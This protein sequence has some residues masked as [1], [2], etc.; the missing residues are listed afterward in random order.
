MS[1]DVPR[2]EKHLVDTNGSGFRDSTRVGEHHGA[3]W[4][5]TSALQSSYVSISLTSRIYILIIYSTSP[6]NLQGNF[7]SLG[8]K[9]AATGTRCGGLPLPFSPVQE[10]AESTIPRKSMYSRKRRPWCF[11]RRPDR[12]EVEWTTRNAQEALPRRIVEI[13]PVPKCFHRVL[14]PLRVCHDQAIQEH[15]RD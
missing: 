11:T 14:G 4:W 6:E 9:P 2:G 1:G 15:K 3:S 12:G 13:R 8:S 5:S 7:I 10:S